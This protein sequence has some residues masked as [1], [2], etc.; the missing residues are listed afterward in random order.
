MFFDW[1][2]KKATGETEQDKCAKAVLTETQKALAEEVAKIRIALTSK[3]EKD[4]APD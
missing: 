1:L 3:Q 2:R 4:N